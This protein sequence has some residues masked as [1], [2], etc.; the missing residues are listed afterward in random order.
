MNE[1]TK[2]PQ[3]YIF[4][5][6]DKETKE[7][8][9]NKQKLAETKHRDCNS[10]SHFEVEKIIKDDIKIRRKQNPFWVP[11]NN[12]DLFKIKEINKE[13][14]QLQRHK[15]NLSEPKNDTNI[16]TYTYRSDIL[17]G[18]DKNVLN[19][20]SSIT[21]TNNVLPN[22]TQHATNPRIYLT[23]SQ[24]KVNTLPPQKGVLITED[25]NYM[26]LRTDPADLEF[27]KEMRQKSRLLGGRNIYSIKDY[28]NQTKEIIL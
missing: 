24:L 14:R 16:N 15:K 3:D 25:K 18:V 4:D 17:T 8:K 13:E 28:I 2:K 6:D 20:N 10:I 22:I 5:A 23:E 27:K 7:T 1:S 12:S 19:I 26:K 9:E 11:V 21:M